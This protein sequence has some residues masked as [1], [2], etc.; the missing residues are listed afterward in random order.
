MTV[1][2]K[3]DGKLK[4]KM[5]AFIKSN[6]PIAERPDLREKLVSSTIKMP[7]DIMNFYDDLVEDGLF[8]SRSEA[9]RYAIRAYKDFFTVLSDMPSKDE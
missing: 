5:S 7:R 6:V 2:Q 3:E 4:Y 8:S 1:Q 9:L